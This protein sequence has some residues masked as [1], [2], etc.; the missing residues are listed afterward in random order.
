MSSRAR[1]TTA[2]IVIDG[3][4]GPG[5]LTSEPGQPLTDGQLQ[6]VRDS[7]LT[8]VL[9]TVGTVGTMTQDEAF[10]EAVRSMLDMDREIARH[11]EIVAHMT[12]V[13]GR[14]RPVRHDRVV[15]PVKLLAAVGMMS[16][17]R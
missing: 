10:K 12:A 11:P 1:S 14:R 16:M 3:L 8:A 6:D 7:G 17:W 15:T 9:V 4:G 2:A 13:I 5:S